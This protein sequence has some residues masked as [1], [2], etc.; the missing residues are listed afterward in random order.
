MR[1]TLEYFLSTILGTSIL[2]T[3]ISLLCSDLQACGECHSHVRMQSYI[4]QNAVFMASKIVLSA[5]QMRIYFRKVGKINWKKRDK[6]LQ[7]QEHYLLNQAMK[8]SQVR[9][10]IVVRGSMA[11]LCRFFS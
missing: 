5:F 4:G 10:L 9:C 1:G 2:Y 11:I 7:Q 6:K 8:A 3:L